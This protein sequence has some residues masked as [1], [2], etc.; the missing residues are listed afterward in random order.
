MQM[1]YGLAAI[2]I[3]MTLFLSVD[4][5]EDQQISGNNWHVTW[6][7]IGAL[8]S[9]I[10]AGILI[11]QILLQHA[12]LKHTRQQL[13]AHQHQLSHLDA[14]YQQLAHDFSNS[15]DQQFE[16]WQLT[17]SE[18]QVARLLIKGLSLAEI[19]ALRETK[20]KTVR[21]QASNLYTKSGL[22][23]RHALTAYFLEDLLTPTTAETDRINTSP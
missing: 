9:L 2:F 16:A 1:M 6:E 3:Y 22:D 23:G 5:Y 10:G 18:K 4:I 8:V 12:Q 20:E 19:A 7:L 21:Q 15:I 11:R 17:D 14:R 13:D